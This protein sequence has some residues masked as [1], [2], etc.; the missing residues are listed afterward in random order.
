MSKW[1]REHGHVSQMISLT[2]S[3]EDFDK[4][5]DEWRYVEGRR[6]SG[7]FIGKVIPIRRLVRELV[8]DVMHSHYLSSGGFF[9]RWSGHRVK[10]A[11]SW[12]SDVFQDAQYFSKRLL[13]RSAIRGS[14]VVIGSSDIELKA[15]KSYSPKVRT[16]KFYIGVDTK[17]F[18]PMPNLKPDVFTFLSGRSSYPLY[19]PIRIVKAFELL[20]GTDSRLLIQESRNPY[21]ELMEYIKRSPAKDRIKGYPVRDHS[22]MPA[23]YNKAHVTVSI[24][25]SDS[26]S[27]TMLESMACAVPVIAS[28]IPANDEWDGTSIYIPKDDTPEALAELMEKMKA[29]PEMTRKNGDFAREVI[30]QRADWGKQMEGLVK[31]YEELVG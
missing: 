8:P 9:G 29:Q 28:K 5:Y 23:L 18:A 16:H 25:D 19:N 12:G 11:H 20:K 1:F 13:V 31:L 3:R 15:V 30:I 6:G 27:A 17:V 10:I 21:P 26:S 2:R 4:Q 24:P 22:E 14:D 7:G